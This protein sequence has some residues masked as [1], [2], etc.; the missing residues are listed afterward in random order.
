MQKLVSQLS[1]RLIFKQLKVATVESCTGGWIGKTLTDQA[2]S[3]DW[4]AGGL[5][6]YTNDSKHKLANVPLEL[7]EK[8]GAVSLQVVEA[9]ALGAHNYFEDCVSVAVSG[10]AGPGGGSE[11]KPVGTVCIATCLNQRT[12]AKCYHFDGDRNQVRRQ[13]VKQALIMLMDAL[14]RG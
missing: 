14:E 9:M 3:S 8:Y 12:N 6:T 11:Q 7:I 1:V 13:T 4:F 10:V 5:I 2:G